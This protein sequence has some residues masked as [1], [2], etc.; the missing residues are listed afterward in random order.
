M[1]KDV[2]NFA[3]RL[4][5]PVYFI[6]FSQIIFVKIY[7][8]IFVRFLRGLLIHYPRDVKD[9]VEKIPK[10][11]LSKINKP[12]RIKLWSMPHYTFHKNLLRLGF[13]KTNF[14]TNVC[15]YKNLPRKLKV[16]NFYLSMGDSDIY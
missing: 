14:K 13:K 9:L 1:K 4:W 8:A 3:L 16:K 15:T 12:K 6:K 11:K 10:T 5:R 2:I 7:R